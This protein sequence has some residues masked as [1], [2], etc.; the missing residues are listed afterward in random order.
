MGVGTRMQVG[1]TSD[2]VQ[3]QAMHTSSLLMNF[4]CLD[5]VSQTFWSNRLS[6][7]ALLKR[8]GHIVSVKLPRSNRLG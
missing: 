8:L 7:T 6:Q 2:A 5:V 3:H 4:V 1:C